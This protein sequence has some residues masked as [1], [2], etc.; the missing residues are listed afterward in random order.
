MNLLRAELLRFVTRRFFAVMLVVIL[1]ILAVSALSFAANSQPVSA[2]DRRIAAERAMQDFNSGVA[3]MQTMYDNCVADVNSPTPSGEYGSTLADCNGIK[4]KMGYITPNPIES[5]LPHQFRLRWE[6]EGSLYVAAA[7]LAVFG[8]LVGASFVGAEWTSGGMTNLLLWHPQRIQVLA[9]KL[10]TALLGVLAVC[11]AYTAVWIGTLY[12]VAATRGD[13]S[14]ATAGF[15]QSITLLCVRSAVLAMIGAA[16]G[17]ALAML[18]RHTAMALGVGIAYAMIVEI[19][20][21][22]IFGLN[23]INFPER[24]Q[25]ATYVVAWLSKRVELYD[26]GF[27][28][29]A[30]DKCDPQIYVIDLP[31]SGTVLG[32]VVAVLVGAAI[33][34]FRRRD[35]A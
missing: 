22:I 18:G 15:W 16:I 7:I 26:P 25:L 5:Y 4:E 14:E 1:A 33:L 35:V 6:L 28:R 12:T 9:A 30:F 19:G 11:A 17:F 24:F 13:T 23:A 21:R 32:V 31:T 8:F 10:G 2:D 3:E 34:V 20:T 27:C 29:Y